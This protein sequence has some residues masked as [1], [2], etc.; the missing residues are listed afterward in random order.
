MV[1]GVLLGNQ[2]HIGDYGYR[3]WTQLSE[4][5]VLDERFKMP[6]FAGRCHLAGIVPL[7][8]DGVWS[9]LACEM[10]FSMLSGKKIYMERKVPYLLF[11]LSY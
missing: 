3:E 2:V 5:R 7:S 1:A 6:W 8:P 4:L 10:I 11:Y 9:E